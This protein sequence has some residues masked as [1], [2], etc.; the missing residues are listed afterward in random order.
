[1]LSRFNFPT[2]DFTIF[3]FSFLQHLYGKAFTRRNSA[4]TMAHR[5]RIREVL[6]LDMA[7]S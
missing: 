4:I 3:S 2:V 5:D 7:T 6:A 1:M